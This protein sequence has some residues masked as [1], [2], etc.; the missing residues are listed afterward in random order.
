MFKGSPFEC[1]DGHAGCSEKHCC[2]P[3]EQGA[4]GTAAKDNALQSSSTEQCSE[5]SAARTVAYAFLSRSTLPLWPLWAEYFDD[6]NGNAVP[7]F[8]VQDTSVHGELADMTG[9]F[10]GFVLPKNET[11]QGDPRFSWKMVAIMLRL[12]HAAAHTR[13]PNGCIP[14]WVITLSEAGAPTSRCAAVHE[15]FSA[16]PGVNWINIASSDKFE[17]KFERSQ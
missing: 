5:A 1:G 13:A 12:Y 6:C 2:V 8:H 4:P 10:N 17:R 11:I 15:H 3:E 14:R 16:R 9:V 7:V